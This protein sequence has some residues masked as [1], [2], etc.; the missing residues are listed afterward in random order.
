ME[1]KEILKN[2]SFRVTSHRCKVLN[3][4][5][6]SRSSITHS[7]LEKTFKQDIDR[8][9][10]YRMLHSFSEK[11]ILC[12]IIDSK[13]IASYIFNNHSH[14]SQ[15]HPHYKCKTCNDVIEL[16][17]LPQEYVNQLKKLNIDELNILAEGTCK[18]C[19]KINVK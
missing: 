13:G 11:Q 1:A 5:M 10:L 9:S 8:V 15:F 12:K 14:V 3:H 16:P 7:D 17:K 19:E 6:K 4:F 2:N 18:E